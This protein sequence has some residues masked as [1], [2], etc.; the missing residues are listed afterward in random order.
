MRVVI[1]WVAH[2]ST[3]LLSNMIINN[4]EAQLIVVDDDGELT[5]PVTFVAGTTTRYFRAPRAAVST[6]TNR[7]P[8]FTCALPTG[9][10]PRF[11]HC[12][13]TTALPR[14]APTANPPMA[15][16]RPLS[17]LTGTATSSRGSATTRAQPDWEPYV[18]GSPANRAG[19]FVVV[20]TVMSADALPSARAERGRRE[21]RLGA[22]KS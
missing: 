18:R 2:G 7:P 1:A 13:S 8:L 15:I 16:G 10:Q 3:I 11:V 22:V 14:G 5:R 20:E 21:V 4:T 19:T 9:A 12:W 6:K 17:A